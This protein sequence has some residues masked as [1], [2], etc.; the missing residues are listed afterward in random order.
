VRILYLHQYFNTP[1][2]SG[3]TRSYEM[4]RRMVEWGHSVELLTA[5]RSGSGRGGWSVEE[6]DG[7][8]VHWLPV[9]YSNRMSYPR[10]L[11]AFG[12]FAAACA[13]RASRIPC[14]VVLASSTPLTIA[15]PGVLAS[16]RQDAPMVFE[17]RDLWPEVPVAMRALRNP[18]V[19]ALARAMER[20]AYRHSARV[21]ALSPGMAEGV[22]RAGYPADRVVVIPNG[23]D[24]DLFDPS[25]EAGRPFRAE[26]SWLEARPLVLYAGTLGRVN[27]VGYLADVA[28]AMRKLD[29]DV[30]F[31]VVGDGAE[32]EEVEARAARLGV[33][34]ESFHMMP[35]QPKSAM[36]VLLS[37]ATVA[38]SVVVDVPELRHNSANKFFDALAAGRPVMINHEGWQADLLRASGAGL[39]VPPARPDEAAEALLAFLRDAARLR[40]AGLAAR[41]LAETRFDRDHLAHTLVDVLEDA[42]RSRS[43]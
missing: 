29:E 20:W 13:R 5:R 35:R 28:A 22:A 15:L 42:V 40:A 7:I 36:P 39:V 26:R 31:L 9:P 34:G 37:A 17:V 16:R 41:A 27:G 32:R 6:V 18:A 1:A 12:R 25:P 8:R 14:D 10:R 23:C 4:A 43:A 33:L 19:I 3:A 2:M 11:L 38:T 30:R 21:V 24:T